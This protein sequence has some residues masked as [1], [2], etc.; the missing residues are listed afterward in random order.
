MICWK[1]LQNT[2]PLPSLDARM[3]HQAGAQSIHRAAAV[4]RV[5]ASGLSSGL[6]LQEVTRVTGFSRPTVHR[7]L[8]ALV[9]EGLVEQ[10]LRSRRYAIGE[11]VPMLALARQRQSPLLD[12]ASPIVAQAA[13][14]LGDTLFLTVRT[15]DEALCLARRMGPY[16]IQVLVIEVG[17]RRPLGVSSAG[18]A[19]LARLPPEKAS[20]IIL[21]N[22]SRF[23]S[24]RTDAAAVK[25]ELDKTRERGYA[26]RDP[27]LIPGTK[28]LSAAIAETAASPT[29][30]LTIAGIPQRMLA[31]REAQLARDLTR[32]AAEVETR[33]TP[34]ARR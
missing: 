19:I 30:A 13:R 32:F 22:A 14:E 25:A 9:E 1:S 16:P 5:L 7:I 31:R 26:L 27:G 6:S 28:A 29:A 23:D 24:F 4:L 12:A 3:D 33:L 21:R 17:A 10:H 20:N 8:H 18:L 11:Q 34:S 15:G 2:A